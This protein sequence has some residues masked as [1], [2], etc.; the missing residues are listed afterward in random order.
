MSSSNSLQ[1]QDPGRLSSGGAVVVELDY[2]C[3]RIPFPNGSN[4]SNLGNILVT[5]TQGAAQGAVAG[6]G[7]DDTNVICDGQDR[8]AS[9][10]VPPN[11]ANK[12]I[13]VGKAFV[14]ATLT[15]KDT[16]DLILASPTT[17]EISIQV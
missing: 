2:K 10:T 12:P 14:T 13:N 6:K 3:F 16:P 9:V 5:I 17:R 8:Q 1:I 15:G 4:T 11:D 7:N